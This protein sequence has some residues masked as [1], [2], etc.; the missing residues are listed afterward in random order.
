[1]TSPERSS[2]LKLYQHVI[3]RSVLQYL[4]ADQGRKSKRGIYSPAVFAVADDAA[5]VCRGVE[6]WLQ[7]SSSS[8]LQGAAEIAP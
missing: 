1:M 8:M 6:R 3:Y 2:L 4:E 5:S 7:W